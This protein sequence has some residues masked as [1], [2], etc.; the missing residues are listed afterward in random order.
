MGNLG[1]SGFVL[2]YCWVR[3]LQVVAVLAFVFIQTAM[4]PQ[5]ASLTQVLEPFMTLEIP[6]I[7]SRQMKFYMVASYA[8]VQ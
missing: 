7:R 6:V 2:P 5:F 8:Y 1:T 4:F 3:P